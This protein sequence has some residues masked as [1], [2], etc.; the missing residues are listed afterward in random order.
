MIEFLNK[1]QEEYGDDDTIITIN[2]IESE[3]ASKKYGLVWEEHEERVDVE[4]KTKV[5]VFKEVLDKE[6]S[7]DT[8]LPINFLLEGDNLHSLNLLEKTHKGRVDFIYIVIYSAIMYRILSI[9]SINNRRNI[10]TVFKVNKCIF[11]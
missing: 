11:S 2:E 10:L 3:L 8:E 6:I 1:L 9:V 4:M 7:E 5:P